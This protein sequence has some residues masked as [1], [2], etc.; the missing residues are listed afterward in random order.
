MKGLSAN[1]ILWKH[2][3]RNAAFPLIT[4]LGGLLPSLLAGSILIEEIFDLPGMGDLLYHSAILQD[5]PVVIAL[6][7]INGLL[8]ITG[9]FL[10]DICYA[11]LDPRVRL[12]KVPPR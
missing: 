12:G 3:F 11:L 1:E 8:T 9:L 6:V 10:A 2:I 7:L 5:W 4:L